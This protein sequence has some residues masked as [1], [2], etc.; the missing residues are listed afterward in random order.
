MPVEFQI[1]ADGT[2]DYQYF[3]VKTNFTEDKWIAAGEVRVGD[4]EHVHH[5]TVHVDDRADLYVLALDAAGLSEESQ[6]TVLLITALGLAATISTT[7]TRARRA[8]AERSAPRPCS[9]CLCS[10]TRK[11]ES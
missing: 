3:E 5:A 1:P 9:V 8:S 2:V 11:R 7:T 10:C 4:R 6:H